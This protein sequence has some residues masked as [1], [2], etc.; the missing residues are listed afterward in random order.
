MDANLQEISQK[1]HRSLLIFMIIW[2][3]FIV[4]ILLRYP[5]LGAYAM[6]L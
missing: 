1:T 4:T 2:L 6:S 5:S 3:S